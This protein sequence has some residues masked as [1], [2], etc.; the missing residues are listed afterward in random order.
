MVHKSAP[1]ITNT[2]SKEPYE[3]MLSMIVY[4]LPATPTPL[5]FPWTLCCFVAVIVGGGDFVAD[6]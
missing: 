2:L 5:N 6:V 3:Y 1:K 4:N